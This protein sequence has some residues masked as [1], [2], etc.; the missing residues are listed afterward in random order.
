VPRPY[1]RFCFCKREA[2]LDEAIRRLDA[3]FTERRK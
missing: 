3:H 2:V 1:L